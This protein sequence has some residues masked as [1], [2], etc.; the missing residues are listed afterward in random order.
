MAAQARLVFHPALVLCGERSTTFVLE[1]VLVLGQG[2]HLM[3]LSVD[4]CGKR[5]GVE[6]QIEV[7]FL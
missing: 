7:E 5:D 4:V 2:A 6:T 1:S 3:L